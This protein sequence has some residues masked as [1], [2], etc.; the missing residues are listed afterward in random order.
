[1]RDGLLKCSRYAFAPNYYRYCGPDNRKRLEGYL[2]EKIVDTGLRE[3][4]VDFE[5]LYPYLKT[6]ATENNLSDP[7]DER[8]VE[9]YWVGNNLL[10][11]VR[12][13]EM[14]ETLLYGQQLKKRLQTKVWRWIT[15]KIPKG[16][17]FHHSFHVFSIFTRTGHLT[18]DHTI[19]SMNE[20]RIG[21]GRIINNSNLKFQSLKI[22]LKTQQLI[23][24][25]GKLVI[26]S[27]VIR[28]VIPSVD[29]GLAKSLKPGDW[30]SYHW[31][32]ICE[33]LT[34]KQVARLS[35]YTRH[36]LRLANETL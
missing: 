31:G 19:D 29:V 5:G 4:L 7:F 30:V 17:F 32:F 14:A 11:Q 8:V 10:H 25:K 2:S 22:Q 18:I 35:H 6:I 3:Y 15:D 34:L 13:K 26:E 16:A 28:E 24:R 36:N 12:Q 23:Y 1:M 27:N 33:K 20:C 21:W 9:A